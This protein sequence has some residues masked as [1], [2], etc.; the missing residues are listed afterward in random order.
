MPGS[1]GPNRRRLFAI[2]DERNAAQVDAVIRPLARD[3]HRAAA[4]A[5]R[6]PIGERDLHRGIDRFR[7]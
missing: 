6:L 4:L 3:E 1:V 5:F 2:P 7:A